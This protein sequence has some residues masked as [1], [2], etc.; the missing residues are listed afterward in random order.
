MELG[1]AISTSRPAA[2]GG[3]FLTE[4]AI[5]LAATA[6]PKEWPT[7]AANGPNHSPAT[8]AASTR[9]DHGQPPA[10]RMAMAR[11][12]ERDDLVAGVAIALD[13]RRMYSVRE[14]PA[15]DD[16][17]GAEACPARLS[18]RNSN[19]MTLPVARLQAMLARF[20]Q[21]SGGTS[22]RPPLAFAELLGDWRP[23]EQFEG[24]AAR[25]GV[26]QYARPRRTRP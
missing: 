23:A 1:A 24:R 11:Q 17:H 8:R 21:K 14:A 5:A 13:Q 19:T 12:V 15:M 6:P 20:G 2:S 22:R 4:P 18:G 9:I 16:Q 25:Q 7:V 3:M 10:R 26:A